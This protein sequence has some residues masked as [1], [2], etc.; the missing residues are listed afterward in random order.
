MFSKR[1]SSSIHQSPLAW[2]TFLSSQDEVNQIMETNL[3]LRH[4][5]DVYPLCDVFSDATLVNY[6]KI[7]LSF[8][9]SGTTTNW[10]GPL[11][12]MMGLSSYEFH[13]IKFGGQTSFCTTSKRELS[14]TNMLRDTN[15]FELFS[16]I[17]LFYFLKYIFCEKLDDD[18]CNFL[19]SFFGKEA[20]F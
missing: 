7:C 20:T 13:P 15:I 9:R 12:S 6:S 14:S 16:V 10:D 19:S 1:I 18:V 8:F 4:V 3:W 17:I 11:L 2:L 5:S